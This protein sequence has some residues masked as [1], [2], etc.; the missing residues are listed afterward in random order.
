MMPQSAHRFSPPRLETVNAS[1]PMTHFF[2]GTTLAPGVFAPTV[3]NTPVTP[4]FRRHA[5]DP[6]DFAAIDLQQADAGAVILADDLR[7]ELIAAGHRDDH[8]FRAEQQVVD[9][10]DEAVGT[11]DGAAAAAGGAQPDRGRDMRRRDMRMDA[12]GG[13]QNFLEQEWRCVHSNRPEN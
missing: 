7:L 3:F 8:V 1:C 10:E 9:G 4:F 11:D 6:G 2:H 5:L 12:D 13:A